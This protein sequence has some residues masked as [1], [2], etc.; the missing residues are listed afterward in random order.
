MTDNEHE[1]L[2]ETA[3]HVMELFDNRDD[4]LIGLVAAIVDLYRIAFDA[5]VNTK[6]AAL[7]RLRTQQ[8]QS[9][10]VVPEGR[11]SKSLESDRRLS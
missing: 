6:E 10:S 4:M 1:L 3:K 7:T 5:G 2:S 11:G 8:E 9:V